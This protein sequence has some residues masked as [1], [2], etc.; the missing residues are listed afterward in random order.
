MVV[1]V[2]QRFE[3]FGPEHFV[4]LAVFA[5]GCAVAVVLGRLE[6][7][8]ATWPQRTAGVM[9]LALCGPFEV[10]EWVHGIEQWR[11]DLPVQ[12][13]D[14]A[15][16]IA[17]VALLTRGARW[18]ALLYFW[19]LT[20]SLQGV[21]T[22]DLDQ[23]F[24]DPQFF[25]FWVRH[26]APV[27]AAVYLIGAGAGPTWRG[28]RFAVAVTALWAGV[29][30]TLNATFGSN[31]GFLNAKPVSHSLLDLLGP[32]PW[33]VVVEVG[34]VVSVW[35]LITWPWNR[36]TRNGTDRATGGRAAVGPDTGRPMSEA[37]LD[38]GRRAHRPHLPG[39]LR[40]A[41]G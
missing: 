13:C 6:A 27:W 15:W 41:R 9:I 2:D 38:A 10:A 35:A 24:P 21:L 14:F 34:I 22:P 39:A 16:L 17:G 36:A 31:Y 18:S 32:W 3:V 25:G 29:V 5:V 7:P 30:M 26:L 8:A 37:G 23:V 33:Y 12:I 40:R 11:T 28:Y 1:L 20:L 4:M 19:G